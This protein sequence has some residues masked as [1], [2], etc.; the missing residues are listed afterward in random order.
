MSWEVV[1]YSY[2]VNESIIFDKA[3]VVVLFPF[4]TQ[5][6]ILFIVVQ[7]LLIWIFRKLGGGGRGD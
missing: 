1:L 6:N 5:R 2:A 4:F 3:A 7:K